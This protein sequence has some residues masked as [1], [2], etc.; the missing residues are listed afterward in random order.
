LYAIELFKRYPPVLWALAIYLA[1]LGFGFRVDV[2]L[3]LLAISVIHFFASHDTHASLTAVIREHGQL[4]FFL[5][6]TV[7]VTLHSQD[8]PHSLQV[9]VH[10]LP[11]LLLYAIVCSCI[12]KQHELEFVVVAVVAGGLV[13]GT[14]FL[15][16]A[17]CL[18]EIPD[19][20]E[21]IYA[22][23]SLLV[24]AP[25][26]VL[27]FSV[28]APLAVFLLLDEKRHPVLRLIGLL[29]LGMTF[30]LTIYMQ[31]RQG[32]GVFFLATFLYIALL[33]PLYGLVVVVV[34]VL[35]I[36]GVDWV[37]GKGLLKKLVYLFPRRYV[38]K[39]AWQMY[40]DQPL[41]GQGPGMF[42]VLYP[43]FLEKAGYILSQ[44][45]DRRPMNWAHSLFLEQLAE[46]G[47]AGLVA[48]VSLVMIPWLRMSRGR[49]T[50]NI[51]ARSLSATVLAFMLA[52]IAE[53]SLLRLWTMMLVFLL[54]GLMIKTAQLGEQSGA[55]AADSKSSLR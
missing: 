11:A 23:K 20:L 6:V 10:L 32:V 36:L 29:Y 16:Q 2:P 7:A 41:L 17:L 18:A 50:G 3:A 24:I 31:S 26:D 5:L 47:M 1:C 9:Q 46:R 35:A 53:A 54:S 38:W 51:L 8:L 44:V 40:L 4:F 39:S 55:K 48:L 21:K 52:G 34:G 42:R 30:A 27:Y 49:K 45:E 12:T 13:S 19:P 25:N 33:R 37:L 28:M 22:I 15:I 43:E 14:A